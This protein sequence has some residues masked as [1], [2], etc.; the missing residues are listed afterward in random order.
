MSDFETHPIGTQKRMEAMLE[1]VIH[2]KRHLADPSWD[3]HKRNLQSALDKLRK[4]L[5][6]E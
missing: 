5:P 6:D 2:A 3:A 4:E 1:V